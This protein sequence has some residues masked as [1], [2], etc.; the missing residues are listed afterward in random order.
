MGLVVSKGR[1]KDFWTGQPPNLNK[2]QNDRI[3]PKSLYKDKY[4]EQV[5]S[6]LNRTLI[7]E[8]TNKKKNNIQPS[9][10]FEE[11]FRRTW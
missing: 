6:I 1:A 5:N 11:C 2:C 4:K 9:E 7:S 3:F 10:F 8:K